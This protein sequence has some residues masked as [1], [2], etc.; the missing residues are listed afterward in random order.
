MPT[1]D[2]VS[3]RPN[4]LST[5]TLKEHFEA[6]FAEQ[7]RAIEIAERERE[8]ASTA[9]REEQRHA[10]DVAEREREKAAVALRHEEQRSSDKAEREREKAA[11]ALAETL[12]QSIEAGDKGLQ[13][14]LEN[15][16]LL[17]QAALDAARREMT[18]IQNASKEAI[19]KAEV[20]TQKQ[21]A[22]SNAVRGQMADQLVAHRDNLEKLVRE[23]MPREVA[24]SKLE[25]MRQQISV[26]AEKL[27]RLT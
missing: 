26:L 13:A 3:L 18:I 15:Q 6:L 14:N 20:A 27:G 23:L 11:L 22:S 4:A 16:V 25:E 7:Q 19:D 12:H 5:V 10:A 8:K 1:D 17:F 2:D 24:E 9:L 21:F